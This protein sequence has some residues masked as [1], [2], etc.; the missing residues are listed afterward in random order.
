MLREVKEIAVN[1]TTTVVMIGLGLSRLSG[2]SVVLF[3]KSSVYWI[4]VGCYSA[5]G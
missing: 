5:G 4:S 2:E 3:R 1:V